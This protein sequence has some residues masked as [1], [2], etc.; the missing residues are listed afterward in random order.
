[1]LLDLSAAL[2]TVNHRILLKRLATRFGIGRLAL[3]WFR[4]YLSNC[5][6]FVSVEGA[7]STSRSF[8]C[9][10]SQGSM[11]G[12]IPFMLYISPIGDLV[13]SYDINFHLYSDDSEL[14]ITFSTS[15]VSQ[16]HSAKLKLE[17]CVTGI[18]RWMVQ[19]RLIVKMNGDKTEVFLPSSSYRPS[20]IGVIIFI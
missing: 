12:P 5:K 9:G 3:E 17:V 15:S 18:D 19:N 4:S 11:L 14:Y 16:L 1:M 20:N 7:K 13:P 10:V 6:S 8:N 2:D